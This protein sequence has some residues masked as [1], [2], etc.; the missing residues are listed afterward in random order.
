MKWRTA[1][2]GLAA[3]SS[4]FSCGGSA[5]HASMERRWE[6]RNSYSSPR[7]KRVLYRK[8]LGEVRQLRLFSLSC[9]NRAV[10]QLDQIGN[11]SDHSLLRKKRIEGLLLESLLPCHT[12]HSR[13]FPTREERG[14][15]WRLP[16]VC[17]GRKDRSKRC[18]ESGSRETR[19][20]E[21]NLLRGLN[22]ERVSAASLLTPGWQADSRS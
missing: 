4:C 16:A 15:N 8:A 18:G 6:L 10:V 17:R 19:T 21:R 9:R 1:N 11:L 12:T 20:L 7:R 5:D 22:L 14:R 13:S 3:R 2:V